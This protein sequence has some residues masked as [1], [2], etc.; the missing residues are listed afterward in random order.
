MQRSGVPGVAV[1]VV[2]DDAV[3]YS[4]GFG[5]RRVGTNDKVDQNTVFQLASV[6]KPLGATVIARAVGRRQGHLGR[7]GGQAPTGL[8]PEGLGTRPARSRSPTSTP[9]AAGCRSDV[10]DLLESLFGYSRSEI[11]RRS[12]LAC[13]WSRCA[14]STPTRNYGITAAGVAVARGSPDELG[15]SSREAPLYQAAGDDLHELALQRL[16]TQGPTG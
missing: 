3:V 5:V 4:K 9:I 15:R 6:S 7:P 14:R 2:K 13:R 10:G 8:P 11:L 12:A 16:R 1:A